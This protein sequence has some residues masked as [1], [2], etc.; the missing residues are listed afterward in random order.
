MRKTLF[1]LDLN[2]TATTAAKMMKDNGV[3]SV[4]VTEGGNYVGI[5]TERDMLNRVLGEGK[6]V[7]EVSLREIMSSPVVTISPRVKVKHALLLMIHH[8]FRR[9]LVVDEGKPVGLIAQRF[10][11]R[12]EV[13]SL[14]ADA[15]KPGVEAMRLHP[16]YK[17]KIEIIPKV[18]VDSIRDFSIWYTPG[19]AEPCKAISRDPQLVYDFTNKWNSVAIVT[20]GSR[21]LGLGNI[22]PE[23]GMPVMEGK[24]LLYKYLGGVD[25]YPICLGTQ[26]HDEIVNAVKWISPSFGGINLEDIEQPKCF[27]VL[28]DLVRQSNIPVW[29][30]DQQGTATV[31]LAGLI[32]ALRY[33]GTKNEDA[34]ITLVGAGAANMRIGMLL[35]AAGFNV[36]EM[37]IVDSKGIINESRKDLEK[38]YHQKWKMALTTNRSQRSGGIAEAMSGSDVVIALSRSGPN[39]LTGEMIHGMNDAPV[40]FAL[41]NP[42]PEIWP[43][44]AKEAGALIVATGRSDFANQ[45][46]NSLGFPGIFRGALDARAGGIT[47]DMCIAAAGEI[48]AM[49]T[50]ERLDEDCIMP[51][52][53]EQDLYPRVAATV[54]SKAVE[55]GIAGK[56]LSRN[57]FYGNAKKIIGKSREIFTSLRRSGF[58]GS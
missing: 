28:D 55:L 11:L 2:E 30:D 23:A 34:V 12:D 18:P 7:N 39:I 33:R 38:N 58:I 45:I 5:V 44:D 37:K 8:N 42:V 49:V 53:E 10:T 40:V 26:N 25:A 56:K 50:D 46:N 15:Y 47:D 16:I 32:N 13:E 21:I 3:G 27:A 51:G 54:A 52:M 41:A 43:W 48:A 4:I 20:D 22:G 29:H 36:S 57:D 1:M 6:S 14:I 19:V 31:V 35:A 9:L 24:A 17:G